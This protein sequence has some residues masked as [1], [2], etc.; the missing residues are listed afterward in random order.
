MTIR[1][2]PAKAERVRLACQSLLLKNDMRIRE[3]AQVI[4]LIVSSLPEVQ[5]G[6]LHYRELEKTK[7]TALQPNIG[8][9]DSPLN[10]ST[11]SRSELTWWVNNIDPSS[12]N[13]VQSKP[14]LT[15]TTD[16]STRGWGA[17]YGEQK[18]GGFGIWKNKGFISTT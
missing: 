15:L 14:D 7:I 2:P 4:G 8:N 9:Y 17:V 13:I 3:V 16:A 12:K 10:L 5:F 6:E 18:T 11:E 1:L